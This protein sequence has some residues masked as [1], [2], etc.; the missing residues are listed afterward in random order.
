VFGIATG[1]EL[2]DRGVGVRVLVGSRIFSTSSRPALVAH[3]ASYPVATGS[4]FPG[5]KR[6]RLQADHSPSTIADVK[7]TWIYTSIRLYGVVLN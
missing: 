2:E 6:P 5:V 4:P 3:P 7:K 1:Y